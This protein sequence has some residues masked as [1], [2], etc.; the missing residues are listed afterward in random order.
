MINKI[1]LYL[2]E[3]ILNIIFIFCIFMVCIS[4]IK[5]Y[6]NKIIFEYINKFEDINIDSIMYTS[7]KYDM[8]VYYPITNNAK[9]NNEINNMIK[10]YVCRIKKDTA[11]FS[12][13]DKDDKFNLLIEYEVKRLNKNIISFIFIVNYTYK[14][15]FIESNIITKNYNLKTDKEFGLEQL[16]TDKQIYTDFLCNHA[17]NVITKNKKISEYK[18]NWLIK[19]IHNNLLDNFDGYSFSNTHLSLYLNTNKISLEYTNIYEIKI[20]WKDIKHL[21]KHNIYLRDDNKKTD[22]VASKVFNEYENKYDDILYF[23]AFNVDLS[24]ADKVIALTFDD[25]PHYKYTEKI[26]NHLEKNNSVATFFVLGTKIDYSKELLNRMVSLGCEIGNHSYNHKLLTKETDDEVI[27]QIESVNTAI[28]IVTGYDIRAVRP[29]Y[30][31]SNEK[32]NRI[33]DKPIVLWNIDPQDWKCKDSTK[34]KNHVVSK[35][36]NGSIV[37][38]HDIYE[39]SCDA[40]IMIIDELISK[41]FKFVTV[42]QML[43]L[44]NEDTNGIIFTHKK[45]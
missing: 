26:L 8:A 29:P 14:D 38:L 15:T 25:G 45:Q 35:A 40:T 23:P 44:Q 4:L 2:S 37:L 6:S 19:D 27:N 13:K 16:M 20:P 36:E 43:D 18:K 11:Y 28:K 31:A 41:G 1:C 7:D 5:I 17:I 9:I 24:N 21:L 32:M 33:I 3:K 10:K 42:S 12:P 30:G 34:I 39:S 22:D